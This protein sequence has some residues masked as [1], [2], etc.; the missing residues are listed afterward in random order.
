MSILVLQGFTIKEFEQKI[1]LAEQQGDLKTAIEAYEYLFLNYSQTDGTKEQKLE[2]Q[3]DYTILL[4]Y[5][6]EYDKAIEI[7]KDLIDKTENNPAQ[8]EHLARG[9]MQMGLIHFFLEQ[10]DT[11]LDYY[12]RAN[13]YASELDNKLAMSIANNNIGNIYQKRL[14]YETAIDCY[15][16]S[17][18][19]Q[20]EVKDSATICNTIFNIGTCY[21]ELGKKEEALKNYNKAYSI[22]EAIGDKEISSLSNI[23]I[24]ILND[25]IHQ[26]ENSIHT[27]K[28]SGHRQVLLEAYI[29]YAS[30]K[31]QSGDY[32]K[33]YTYVARAKEL[34]DSLFKAEAAES[35]NEFSIKYKSRELEASKQ[36]QKVI[37]IASAIALIIV[38]ISL[39][40]SIQIHRSANRKLKSINI[41]KDKFIS[42]VS[43]DIKN[44]LISQKNILEPLVTNS[45]Y[46]PENETKLLNKELLNSTQ[47]LLIL[48]NN[49]LSWS[50]LELRTI[51]YNPTNID[52]LGIIQETK[53]TYTLATKEKNINI[54]TKSPDKVI[55]YS[56]YNMAATVLRNLINNA[57]KFSHKDSNIEIII[58]RTEN[59]KH[60]K[61]TVKDYG[62]GMDINTQVSKLGTN[63]ET[64][65]GLGLTLTKEM[66]IMN[67][68][69][70]SINSQLGVGTEF[71]FTIPQSL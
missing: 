33:A 64:G 18:D 28:E 71:S 8:K 27:V 1:A 45:I 5:Y 59:E 48:L 10:F 70:Y 37:F 20:A 9:C 16:K 22:A 32:K 14:D 34:S 43:H 2:F 6:G 62:I 61:I 53:A 41:L 36:L 12:N 17:L 38:I 23:N 40:V 4:S 63:G 30:L 65:S 26:I 29:K 13:K 11:A 52:I 19:Y 31:A 51:K 15:H 67:K 68:G 39:I 66:I 50:S 35:I 69:K 24:G 44:P 57:I 54:I 42:V 46:L 21:D 3:L 25:D 56:D 55:A 7:L 60:W 58:T 49:L 47:S